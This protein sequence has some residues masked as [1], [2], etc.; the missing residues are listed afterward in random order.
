MKTNN[1][2]PKR[3]NRSYVLR[4]GR[5]SDA[6]KQAFNDHAA[7]FLMTGEAV[8]LSNLFEN[9]NPIHVEIGFGMGASLLA[10]ATQNSDINY[11]GVE[12]HMPG[13]GAVIKIAHQQQLQNL[14]LFHGDV[15]AFLSVIQNEHLIK[16]WQILFPD[17]W[18]KKRHHKRRLIQLAFLKQLAEKSH[19]KASLHIATDW[20]PYAE[21]VA[22]ILAQQTIW[23]NSV[24]SIDIGYPYISYEAAL[25]LRCPT[26]YEARGK[27]LGHAIFDFLLLK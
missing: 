4:Q 25:R 10:Q 16:H 9:S 19:A 13:I 20:Q 17:P 18:P 24:D 7:Q 6:Q 3:A 1:H 15:N 27:R 5:M 2:F 21:Y 12:V 22:E 14:K 11:I 23:K 8:D 26:K